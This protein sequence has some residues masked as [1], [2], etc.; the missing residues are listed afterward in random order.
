LKRG[1]VVLI[2]CGYWL[3]YLLLFS[4]LLAVVGAQVR[5]PLP[6]LLPPLALLV[7]CLSPNLASFYAFYSLLAPRFL[8]RK[9][10][11]ALII[12]GTAVCLISAVAG[13]LLSVLSFGFGQAIFSDVREFLSL[14]A[15]LCAICAV[16][17][18]AGLVLRGFVAWYDELTLKEELTRRNF[19]TELALLK[20]QIN[21]H[22]LFNTINNIDVL[23]AKDPALA[24]GCTSLTWSPSTKSTRSKRGASESKTR[25][26][27]FQ[28]RTE[29]SSSTSSTARRNSGPTMALSHQR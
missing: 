2:H 17:G 11:S 3:V 5:R 20:S 16:H 24:S 19:E 13:A 7:P 25:S 6:V 22:F 21:P 1:V 29:S 4:L 10:I 8:V 26:F 28:R 15:S 14:T 27:R 23:I 9:R 18:G 12:F